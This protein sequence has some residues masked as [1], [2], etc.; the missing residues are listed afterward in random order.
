MEWWEANPMR[1][2]VLIVPIAGGRFRARAGEPFSASA[3][4]PSAEEARHEL[5]TLL[6]QQLQNGHRLATIDL[7][8]GAAEPGQAPLR[9][10][11]V[12]DDDWFFQT[13]RETIA[14]NRQRE[15]GVSP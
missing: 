10:E 8:N 14:D 1:I 5:E 13:M 15:D 3:E 7:G 9:F 4:G 6:R 2:P 12:A 11:P